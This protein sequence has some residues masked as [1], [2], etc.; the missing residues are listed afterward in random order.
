M[1]TQNVNAQLEAM[2]N[3]YTCFQVHTPAEFLTDSYM[4]PSLPIVIIPQHSF[5]LYGGLGLEVY[6]A[7]VCIMHLP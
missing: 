7:V 3:N 6:F 1:Q 5:A 2:K 4:S